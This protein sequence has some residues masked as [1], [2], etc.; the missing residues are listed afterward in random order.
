LSEKSK[1]IESRA[2]R[3]MVKKKMN[4][5]RS[6]YRPELKKITDSYKCG[7]ETSEIYPFAKVLR[8][9]LNSSTNSFGNLEGGDNC[10]SSIRLS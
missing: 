9:Y 6:G 8:K 2:D 3:E 5:L 10:S 7:A 1:E 4:M